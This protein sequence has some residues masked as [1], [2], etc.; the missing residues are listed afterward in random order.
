MPL[1][2]PTP[3]FHQLPVLVDFH[4]SIALPEARRVMAAIHGLVRRLEDTGAKVDDVPPAIVDLVAQY[5]YT[6]RLVGRT[7]E[8]M[9]FSVTR[10]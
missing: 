7:R 4:A 9:E 8:A 1:V 10:Q 5:G 2:G 3:M 6:A